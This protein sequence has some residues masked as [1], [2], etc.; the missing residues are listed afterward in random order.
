MHKKFET[1]KLD[2][3]DWKQ[4]DF[5]RWHLDGL[6]LD[7]AS[8]SFAGLADRLFNSAQ[9]RENVQ[10]TLPQLRG[11]ALEFFKDHSRELKTERATTEKEFDQRINVAQQKAEA[12]RRS[13]EAAA[14][15]P[16]VKP[17]DDVYHLAVKV[18]A[19][20]GR[21]GLPGLTVQV[22]DPKDPKTALAQTVTDADGNAV[23]TVNAETA[24][25]LEKNDT[26][27]EILDPEGKALA[28]LPGSVCVRLGQTETKVAAIPDSAA[29]EEHRRAA[30]QIQ[31]DRERTHRDLIARIDTLKNERQKRLECLNERVRDNDA[32]I[33]EI[34][35]SQKPP[36]TG[37]PNEESGGDVEAHLGPSETGS[38]RRKT[39]SP[40]WPGRKK[41]TE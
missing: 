13:S 31:S 23:L 38:S 16:V 2:P 18:N 24:K 3:H 10:A 4:F 20:D 41:R 5:T 9:W 35:R 37:K 8:A 19:E 27:L 7:A 36:T 12:F 28:T 26:N 30:V 40:C 39:K 22:T 11:Q 1:P 32:I 17:G 6:T 21:L 15:P 33:A 25:E 34:E 29:I 14:A